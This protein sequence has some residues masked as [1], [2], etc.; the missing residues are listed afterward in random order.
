M[1][2][3]PV[4]RLARLAHYAVISGFQMIDTSVGGLADA[5]LPKRADAR[6]DGRHR[7]A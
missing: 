6:H 2:P 4:I 1:A 5:F 3:T 7:Q